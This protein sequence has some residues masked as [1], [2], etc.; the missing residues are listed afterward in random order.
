MN[1]KT[2]ITAL[3]AL[4]A[5]EGSSK[6]YKTIK[7]PE[8]FCYNTNNDELKVREIVMTDTA[9]TVQFA[10]DY[11][12]GKNYFRIVKGS[13]L[14]DEEG[15]H[16]PLRSAEGI[17]L[18][19][20]I[21]T[22]EDGKK[23]FTMHFEPMP[24][25]VNVIDFIEGDV[26]QAFMVLGIHDKKT[27]LRIPTPQEI[28]AANPYTVPAD[29]FRTDS[30]TI[31]GHIEDY[32]TCKFAFKSM[33]CDCIDVFDENQE[34]EIVFDISPD[35]S[36]E[37]KFRASYPVQSILK[38]KYPDGVL[39][40]E[41]G[42]PTIKDL[43]IP[44][45][46]YPGDVIDIT[47]KR[48][49]QGDFD[50]I[51]KSEGI[52]CKKDRCYFLSSSSS[53]VSR[54]LKQVE[55]V[56]RIT[57]PL[58]YAGANIYL[59]KDNS[60][61]SDIVSKADTIWQKQMYYISFLNRNYHLTPFEMQLALAYAQVNF[62]NA[63][64]QCA[65]MVRGRFSEYVKNPKGE[66]DFDVKDIAEWKSICDFNNYKLLQ[67]IDFNNPLLTTGDVFPIFLIRMH[68]SYPISSALE[69][70]QLP[71]NPQDEKFEYIQQLHKMLGSSD[72]TLFEQLCIYRD[73]SNIINYWQ[74]R[75]PD[76]TEERYNMYMSHITHPYIRK[77]A[78]QLYLSM[79]KK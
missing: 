19:K 65:D 35:G 71:K 18:D 42:T 73:F 53:D 74:V 9:T 28:S 30:I 52:K 46:A 14:A 56:N 16:Y 17:E 36:F 10:I 26:Q 60:K 69:K 2:I 78:Q 24:K 38:Q 44:F 77:K 54:W 68:Q 34:R 51:Y 12:E 45:F 48:N 62:G 22:A 64:F 20:W 49:E 66:W 33:Y 37:T 4:V 13:Y 11:K 7:S 79:T 67:N 3:L 6:I 75:T 15:K 43:H 57:M 59:N 50:C 76:T 40:Y 5:V 63:L 31:Y 70:Y 41:D 72:K 47:V 27:K 61:F 21:S 32:D 1:K 55:N 29:W 23:N 8:S 25:T 58:L 39:T